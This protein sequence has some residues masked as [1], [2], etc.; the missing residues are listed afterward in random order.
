MHREKMHQDQRYHEAAAEDR[1]DT[2]QILQMLASAKL[3]EAEAKLVEA[4]RPAV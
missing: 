1:K 4:K 2:Q 3:M